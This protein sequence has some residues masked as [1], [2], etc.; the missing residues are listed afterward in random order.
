MGPEPDRPGEG[1]RAA[2][3]STGQSQPTHHGQVKAGQPTHHGQVLA[4]QPTHHGQVLA[5]Q[6]TPHHPP[7]PCSG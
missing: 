5:G 3:L 2:T 6:L 4:G 7:A 1:G